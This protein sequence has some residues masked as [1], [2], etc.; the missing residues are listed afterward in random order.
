MRTGWEG[1]GRCQGE[2]PSPFQGG[3]RGETA[4]YASRMDVEGH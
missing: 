1:R 4:G 3:L 2:D